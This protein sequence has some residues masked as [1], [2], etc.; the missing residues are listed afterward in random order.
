MLGRELP[1]MVGMVMDSILE[2]EKFRDYRIIGN[3]YGTTIVLRYTKSPVLRHSPLWK[4][5][6]PVNV[7]R[8]Y[9]RHNAWI[10]EN[11]KSDWSTGDLTSMVQTGQLEASSNHT[12]NLN[13]P[14]FVAKTFVEM[15]TQTDNLSQ[16]AINISTQTDNIIKVVSC[17]SQCEV[18]N[19]KSVGIK[20]KLLPEVKTKY[21]Q[22]TASK[23]NQGTS[24]VVVTQDSYSQVEK[25]DMKVL[26]TEHAVWVRQSP[27]A[28]GIHSQTEKKEFI[29]Q[30]INTVHNST[31]SVGTQMEKHSK[32]P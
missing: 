27:G 30:I 24:S 32:Y 29:D 31:N 13:A 17:G 21:V 22:A 7:T 3:E 15:E 26:T 6:S 9:L 5:R 20:C 14:E 28:V 12:W 19:T 25:T 18:V 10:K 23:R 11:T 16:C 8:D 2:S 4:D 1:D